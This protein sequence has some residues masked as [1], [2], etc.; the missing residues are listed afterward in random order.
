MHPS[1][2]VDDGVLRCTADFGLGIDVL[3]L[4]KK[5]DTELV[6]DIQIGTYASLGLRD[7]RLEAEGSNVVVPGGFQVMESI[8]IGGGCQCR[9][10]GQQ[11]MSCKD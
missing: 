11:E 6:I 5:S 3:R 9:L 10:P 2:P 1:L 8:D 7:I 4:E